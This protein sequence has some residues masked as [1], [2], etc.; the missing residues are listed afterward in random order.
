[1]ENCKPL[2]VAIRDTRNS[3]LEVLNNSGLPIDVAVMILSDIF[4][5]L[6]KQAEEAFLLE[7][8]EYEHKTGG[9]NGNS[10]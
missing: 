4:M 2:S 6:G 7:K 3:L 1:M 5:A 8:E 9:D 10:N